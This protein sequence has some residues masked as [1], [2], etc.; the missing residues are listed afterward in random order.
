MTMFGGARDILWGYKIYTYMCTKHTI[1]RAIKQEKQRRQASKAKRS[2]SNQWSILTNIDKILTAN[3]KNT[4]FFK[5]ACLKNKKTP[6]ASLKR[7][8]HGLGLPIHIKKVPILL[9]IRYYIILPIYY[10]YILPVYIT[11][12]LPIYYL[13]ILPI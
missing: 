7:R 13:Y 11:Y 5:K 3:D 10:L 9:N 8:K 12:I 6:A 4:P 2:T 1:E